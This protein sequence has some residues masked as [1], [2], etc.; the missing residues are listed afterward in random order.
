MKKEPFDNAIY[1]HLLNFM[2]QHNQKQNLITSS[3]PTDDVCNK[4]PLSRD[5]DISPWPSLSLLHSHSLSVYFTH[6]VKLP[7]VKMEV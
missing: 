2:T 7:K 5:P 1:F 6:I 4:C 3:I